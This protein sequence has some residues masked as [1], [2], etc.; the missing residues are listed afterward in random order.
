MA[1]SGSVSGDTST[2]PGADLMGS[3]AA[4]AESIIR[5]ALAAMVPSS[6]QEVEP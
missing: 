5:E 4:K 6:P 2:R 1:R 3:D